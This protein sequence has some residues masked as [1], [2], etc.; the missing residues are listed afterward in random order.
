MKGTG[1]SKMGPP[2][3]DM[4][5]STSLCK[6]YVWR[7]LRC[8]PN[9]V[10]SNPRLG[11]AGANKHLESTGM[12]PPNS[13][14]P[15]SSGVQR[16]RGG[17]HCAHLPSCPQQLRWVFTQQEQWEERTSHWLG[18]ERGP[19]YAA[20]FLS[21]HYCNSKKLSAILLPEVQNYKWWHQ[22]NLCE[23]LKR[24]FIIRQIAQNTP[25]ICYMWTERKRIVPL[26][27]AWNILDEIRIMTVKTCQQHLE[28]SVFHCIYF[29]ISLQ[30][31]VISSMTGDQIGICKRQ[32]LLCALIISEIV[33]KLCIA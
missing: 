7:K 10:K 25:N 21:T 14:I 22:A 27:T 16:E 20:F 11:H 30:I 2:C 19:L 9:S 6:N 3:T 5:S 13:L 17:E 23:Q 24:E 15:W 1:I 29:P 28:F 12:S 33:Y 18:R 26:S 8:L 4:E 31:Q 32:K